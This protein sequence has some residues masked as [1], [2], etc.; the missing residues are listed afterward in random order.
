[1]EAQCAVACQFGNGC[2]AFAVGAEE[3][4][5]LP[6]SNDDGNTGGKACDNGSRYERGQFPKTQDARQKQQD[7]SQQCGD[8]YAVQTIACHQRCEDGCHSTCWPG[9]LIISACQ[10]THDQTGDDGCDQTGCGIGTGAD[11]E[12]QRQRQRNGGN[13][14]T[15]HQ[16]FHQCG[17]IISPKL[18]FQIFCEPSQ[19]RKNP[20]KFLH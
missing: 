3:V 6:Q 9:D 10:Q 7:T 8:E 4:I 11:T 12:C 17:G 16:V 18:L 20:L 1:M 15:C 19:H 2:G 14:Q 5:D 13:G